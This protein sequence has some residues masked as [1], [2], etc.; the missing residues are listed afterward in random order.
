MVV[1]VNN[2]TV[3]PNFITD[4]AG[5][6]WGLS[7]S[8]ANGQQVCH[9]GVIDVTTAS[10]TLLLYN[11]GIVYHK[12]T[13]GN[14]YSYLAGWTLTGDPR[15][16]SI[17]GMMVTTVGPALIDSTLE[18]WTLVKSATASVGMQIAVNG[19]VDTTTGL[20]TLL[21]YQNHRVYQQ[22][23][24]GGWWYKS[25]SSAV[26]TAS[27]D[28]RITKPV[29]TT[30][31]SPPPQAVA[32]GY[33]IPVLMDEFTSITVGTDS[34]KYNWYTGVADNA[35]KSP[36]WAT[37]IPPSGWSINT[38][39]TG[40]L[41]INADLSGYGA[42]IFTI[43]SAKPVISTPSNA[44]A[45]PTGIAI[46]NTGGGLL[47][48]YGYF[49]ASIYF[50]PAGFQS[51]HYPAWW[52][53]AI[54]GTG[55]GVGN[56]SIPA[57]EIDFMEA[58]I[59]SPGTVTTNNIG[60][61]LI[62]WLGNSNFF[63]TYNGP[64]TYGTFTTAA[65]NALDLSGYNIYGCLWTPTT[66]TFYWNSAAGRAAGKPDVIAYGPIATTTPV[67]TNQSNSPPLGANGYG[68]VAN[69]G[70][71]TGANSSQVYLILGTGQGWPMLVDYVHVWQ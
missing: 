52:S 60:C 46:A 16:E 50:N 18:R 26:W 63:Y 41:T 56:P 48:Q 70:T 57:S 25:V 55:L 66:M 43:C 54:Q 1:S 30:A 42:G 35:G 40:V 4:V 44:I 5:G 31:G 14:F 11:G 68:P 47:Y 53:S 36:D 64:G 49:E 28:P 65:K 32:A 33:T 45:T 27:T 59:A 24:N 12:N 62:Q 37:P 6:V 61:G 39:G 71:F 38:A 58:Y 23:S 9:N 69:E 22:N 15:L 7:P 19:V 67:T 34:G 10:V 51:G 21:L 3:T 13:A 20:V 2:T 29:P 17:N 8:S